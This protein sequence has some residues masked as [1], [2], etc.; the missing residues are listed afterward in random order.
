MATV[1]N[2]VLP[3]VAKG[4]GNEDAWPQ[5]WALTRGMK[6][7]GWKYLASSD[8]STK[9]S[10]TDPA[11]DEWGAGLTTGVTGSDGTL[12]AT[13]GGRIT[14]TAG[15]GTPFV[16][17]DK[18]RFLAVTGGALAVNN[19]YHQIEEV[20]STTV[21][22]LDARNPAFTPTATGETNNGSLNYDVIDPTTQ[23][24]PAGLAAAQ[25]WLLMQGPSTVKVPI[26]AEPADGPT[27]SKFIRSEN[28]VQATTGAEGEILGWVYD[29]DATAGY[30]VVLPRVIGTGGDPYGWDTTY[31]IT[32]DTSGSTVTQVGDALE[33]R[34]QTVFA[35]E[36]THAQTDGWIFNQC[37]EPVGESAESF[38]TRASTA[39]GCTAIVHPGGGGTDNAFPA[40]AYTIQG[41]VNTAG[42]TGGKWNGSNFA[43][44]IGNAQ[45]MCAD[46]IWEENYSAD[47]SWACWM[48]IIDITGQPYGGKAFFR[49]DD[50]EPGDLDP[51]VLAGLNAS[52]LYSAAARTTANNSTGATAYWASTEYLD[53]TLG[54]TYSMFKGWRRRGLAT[55]DAFL[56]FEA[57]CLY[58]LQSNE[59]VCEDTPGDADKVATEPLAT[60]VR[61]PL[62][63]ISTG[64]GQRMRKGSVRWVGIVMGGNPNDTYDGGRFIQLH[65]INGS[66]IAGPWDQTS[67]PA[68]S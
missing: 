48:T 45:V 32:G 64:S 42:N 21:V 1:N 52:T 40:I 22:R 61:E 17:S 37:I 6:K 19:H 29:T 43:Q 55:G 59:K 51:F 66:L 8:G 18:G 16:A 49:M 65:N 41:G 53:N 20:T 56:T 4:P 34:Q 54:T 9:D 39:A 24:Q 46:A 35:K 33:Y 68:S 13:A 12:G 57:G 44:N 27:G 11:L 23:T 14:F 31:E 2:V 60:K 15:S 7:A 38:Y 58:A 36:S 47:G 25:A 26:T 3:N 10:S 63:L 30:L 5:I 50:T 62:W 28:I 67:V